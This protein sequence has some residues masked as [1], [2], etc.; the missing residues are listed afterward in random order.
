[1]VPGWPEMVQRQGQMVGPKPGPGITRLFVIWT[2]ICY[3]VLDFASHQT[4]I[5]VLIIGE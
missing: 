5:R 2:A 3:N 1:M 4:E